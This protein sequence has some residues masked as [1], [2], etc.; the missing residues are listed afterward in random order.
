MGAKCSVLMLNQSLPRNFGRANRVI[1][2]LGDP[3]R[4]NSPSQ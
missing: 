3:A 1:S 4:Q 2:L